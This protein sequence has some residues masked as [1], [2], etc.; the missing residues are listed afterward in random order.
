M[1]SNFIHPALALTQD[2]PL[3]FTA[4]SKHVFYYRMFISKFV[5]EQGGVPLNP[6]ML[7]DY[8]MLDSVDR[9]II[10][11]ANNIGVMRSDELWV[12][13]PIS[14]GVLVEISKCDVTSVEMEVESFRKEL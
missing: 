5:L 14:D 9:D 12:F 1:Q 4:F 8:F 13:G 3:I 6:F 2:K 10:R 11:Q 7:F